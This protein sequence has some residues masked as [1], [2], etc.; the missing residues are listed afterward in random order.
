MYMSKSH[1][2]S[3]GQQVHAYHRV[4]RLYNVGIARTRNI[5]KFL[6]IS[7]TANLVLVGASVSEP[8]T[9]E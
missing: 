1:L 5:Y 3:Q 2:Y 9:D 7:K 8:H 6:K 4:G